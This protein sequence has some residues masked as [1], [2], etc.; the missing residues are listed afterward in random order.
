MNVSLRRSFSACGLS[1]LLALAGC[2][3]FMSSQARVERAQHEMSQGDFR[4]AAIDLRNVLK[5][6]P[7]DPQ[8]RMML[9]TLLLKLGDTRAA[10]S[11]LERAVR[12]G[13]DPARSAPVAAEI[14]LRLGQ[15]A[16][17]VKL[18]DDGKLALVEPTRSTFRGRALSALGK[19]AE[20]AVAFEQAL[21]AEPGNAAAQ[22]GLAETLVVRAHSDEALKLL[23]GIADA[24]PQA[25]EARILQGRILLS[26]GQYSEAE[27]ILLR[28][29][30]QL[31]P[32]TAVLQRAMLWTFLAEAQLAQGKVDSADNTQQIL[33]REMPELAAGQLLRAR[34]HLARGDYATGI[35]ELQ[36]VLVAAPDFV[37]ARMMLGAAQ[38]SQGNFL[39]AENQL[40][41]VVDHAPDNIEARKLLARVRLQL[42]RPDAALRVLTPALEGEGS[43][44]QLYSLAGA[45]QLRA[46]NGEEALATLQQ[47]VRLHPDAEAPR[48]DLASA[49]ISARRYAD[50]LD[51]L[52]STPGK[53]SA[54]RAALIVVAT[55]AQQGQPQ[56]RAELERLIAEQPGNAEL[57]YLAAMYFGSQREFERARV[58]LGHVLEAAPGNGRALRA[59][60]SVEFAAGNV[61]A[62]EQA[63][64]RALNTEP[65]SPDLHLALAR[66]SFSRN[67]VT[68]ARAEIEAAVAASGG[69]ADAENAAGLIFSESQ[70]FDEALARFRRATELDP[71]N[72]SYWLN[73]GRAQLALNQ[74]AAAR[75]SLDKALSLRPDWMPASTLLVLLD[76]RSSGPATALER[77]Q[78]LRR[79]QPDEPA[80]IALEG[81]V[82]M[83][84]KEYAPAARAYQD[85]EQ[86][87]PDAALAV[88]TFEAMRLGDLER[89]EA[90]LIRWL[91]LRPED[92]RVR[93]VLGQYYLQSGRSQRAMAE[94]ETVSRQAPNNSVV[95]NN[96]A[97]LYYTQGDA[98]AEETARRAHEMA[99]SNAA[100]SDTYGWIL[101]GKKQTARALE[102]LEK[103][104]AGA[105]DNPEIRYHYGAAL[106]AAGRHAEAR[107]ALSRA[108][109][110][111][112]TFAQRADAEKL[113]T[114]LRN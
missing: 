22:I 62:A 59:L 64:R 70:R 52:K 66:L 103:A 102:L 30:D 10:Q 18:I 75:E 49:Y 13:I 105:P 86:I 40:A 100:I 56:A 63:L 50:A 85:A 27:T 95:L 11:E 51:V 61:Q 15:P 55:A 73:A 114:Q 41:Q 88:K 92:S 76:L 83:V 46:G 99:P 90:P 4:A 57:L 42:D 54:R 74:S 32:D 77:A 5:K 53:P 23:G 19:P 80:A 79:R 35:A 91:A 78:E 25:T 36:R 7:A 39:Q 65:K 96:L 34:V 113:L 101:L 33:A 20:A 24:D 112:K 108:V 81:D 8:V 93:S 89:P 17:L 45:A 47:A 98:R 111:P 97:W 38:L 87:R 58:Y 1:V 60:A 84:M 48:L 9:A 104:A 16:E 26:R 31:P 12:D 67:D 28:A 109:E 44:P 29:R 6:R 37:Q 2:D 71:G 69:R 106:A 82:R 110:A 107:T 43:D 68:Q 94:L 72:A 14:Q 3:L 21:Q